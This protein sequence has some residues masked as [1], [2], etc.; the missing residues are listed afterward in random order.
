MSHIQQ[1]GEPAQQ[2]FLVFAQ[3]LIGIGDARERLDQAFLLRG[4]K[5]AVDQRVNWW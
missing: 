2:V 4:V 5:P 1:V 3:H